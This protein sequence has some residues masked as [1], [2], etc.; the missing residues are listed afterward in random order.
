MIEKPRSEELG[1]IVS[2][3]LLPDLKP[4]IRCT[5]VRFLISSRKILTFVC[6]SAFTFTIAA[7]STEGTYQRTKDGRTLVWNDA[8]KPGDTATWSGKRDRDGYAVG[9][10]TL[11]WYTTRQSKETV[12]ASFF[13][14]MIRGK[15]D[16]PVNGHSK[17]VTGHAIF[18]QG[19]RIN[20]WATGPVA[21]WRVPVNIPKLENESVTVATAEQT[22]QSHFNPPPPSNQPNASERPIPDY[23]TLAGQVREQPE[24]VP[25]EGPGGGAQNDAPTP[26]KP[27]L[28]IDESL[29]SLTGPPPSLGAVAPPDLPPGSD[30]AGSR[31]P[32]L[33][34]EDAIGLA[35]AAARS[36]GYDVNQY[37]RAEPQ[38][39]AIDQTWSV[40]YEPKSQTVKHFTVAIDD[41]T[42][43]TAV[44]G[45]R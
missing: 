31:G 21:S 6:C 26:D 28:E 15:L 19:K 32:R 1:R 39:D 11:T 36:K 37:Q 10:G 30:A 7:A 33:G 43:R 13:G 22:T 3:K 35:D 27:K 20:R 17:G 34:K 23:R 5:A 9:F 25:A 4:A 41:K 42:G 8:P 45:R 18:S 16:G 29:R 24:G 38:F 14:N 2:S 44:A 40:P 12:F